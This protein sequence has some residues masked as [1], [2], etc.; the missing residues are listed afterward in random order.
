[1]LRTGDDRVGSSRC[2]RILL[3]QMG[4]AQAGEEDTVGG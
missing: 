1:M 3:A 2:L 4:E